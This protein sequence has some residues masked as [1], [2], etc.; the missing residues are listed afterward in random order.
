MTTHCKDTQ[1]FES[2]KN[3]KQLAYLVS[4]YQESE[5]VADRFGPIEEECLAL[6]TS[7]PYLYIEDVGKNMDRLEQDLVTRPGQS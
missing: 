7:E 5:G 3:D 4:L 6:P 2:Q 1:I